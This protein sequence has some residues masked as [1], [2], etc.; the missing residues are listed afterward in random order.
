MYERALTHVEGCLVLF[1]QNY[2]SCAESL[3]RTSLESSI[4]LFY[5]SLGNT[6]ERIVSY[7]KDYIAAERDQ[8]R[9]WLGAANQSE[10]PPPGEET[11][12]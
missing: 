11:S 8:I 9:K 2:Y 3:C 1:S 5:C 10:W 4:N 12:S 7:F 6:E